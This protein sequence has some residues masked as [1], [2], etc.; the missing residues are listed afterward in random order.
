MFT[1]HKKIKVFLARE[2]LLEI[3]DNWYKGFKKHSI[4][5]FNISN[6]DLFTLHLVKL[7]KL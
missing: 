3:R 7:V 4:Q 2:D 1:R 5:L 6:N